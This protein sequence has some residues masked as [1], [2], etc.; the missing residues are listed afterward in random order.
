MLHQ[1]LLAA[2]LLALVAGSVV[3]GASRIAAVALAGALLL[4]LAVRRGNWS[5]R[6]AAQPA[7][8]TVLS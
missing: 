7:G 6:P 4:R 3:G 1:C 8:P 2:Y 5:A